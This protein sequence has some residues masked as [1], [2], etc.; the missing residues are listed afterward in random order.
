MTEILI[1]WVVVFGSA[2][3]VI[4]PHRGYDPL[5]GAILCAIAGFIGIII[6]GLTKGPEWVDEPAAVAPRDTGATRLRE[7]A[8]LRD[9]GLIS[10]DEFEAK[11]ADLLARM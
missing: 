4:A 3:Y 9:D 7:L 10:A 1:L 2:G 6:L 5:Q 8:D 11:K